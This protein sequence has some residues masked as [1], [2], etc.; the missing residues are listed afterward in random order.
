MAYSPKTWG[1][2][3]PITPTDLNRIEKGVDGAYAASV[4][5]GA[6]MP[7]AG[8]AAPASWLLC[9]GSAVSR[10]TYAALFDAIG[11]AYG[12]GDGG[13]TFNLPDMRGNIPLGLDNMGGT[14]RNRITA[15][16]AD[17]LGGQA[18][19]ETHALTAAQLAAHTHT[20]TRN[21]DSFMVRDGSTVGTL[22]SAVW[23]G[24]ASETSSS[25]GSGSAHPNTQPYMALNYII[26]T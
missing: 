15:A 7:F 24:T 26:K 2:S 16:A 10:S 4:P 3:D 8:A 9:D 21:A 23:K 12:V 14:S 20:S 13:T 1:D 25:T 11:T 17:S 22:H 18:G 19:T 6:L 5:P